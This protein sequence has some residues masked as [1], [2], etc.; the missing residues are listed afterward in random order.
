MKTGQQ[1]AGRT[2][3]CDQSRKQQTV[4]LKL[5]SSTVTFSHQ[6]L[7]VFFHLKEENDGIVVLSRWLN[8]SKLLSGCVGAVLDTI[9]KQSESGKRDT[10]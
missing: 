6:L 1:T 7:F 4:F 8:P 3:A 9:S 2:P 5:A 10:V